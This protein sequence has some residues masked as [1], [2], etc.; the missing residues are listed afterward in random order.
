VC[1]FDLCFGWVFEFCFYLDLISLREK[2][3]GDGEEG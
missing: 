1:S 2:K 3:I